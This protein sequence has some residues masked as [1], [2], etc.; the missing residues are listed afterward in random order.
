M[1]D[2]SHHYNS[3]AY[4]LTCL[5]KKTTTT[6]LIW[7]AFQ[8]IHSMQFVFN[9]YEILFFDKYWHENEIQYPERN[10][11]KSYKYTHFHLFIF[12]VII[13]FF[14]L[15]RKDFCIQHSK[16]QKK[17]RFFKQSLKKSMICNERW[18][19]LRWVTGPVFIY[20]F[21]F[22]FL[23]DTD[24]IFYIKKQEKQKLK[25][26]TF[27]ITLCNLDWALDKILYELH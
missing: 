7:N 6:S 8:F 9:G 4:S 11:L 21:S 20:F 10:W 24:S 16:Y 1:T 27:T 25:I 14:C 17:I 26:T 19:H 23:A 22:F 15:V 3:S 13:F 12:I 18:L 5:V 2:S